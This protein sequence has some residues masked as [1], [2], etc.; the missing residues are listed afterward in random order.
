MEVDCDNQKPQ[1]GQASVQ[2]QPTLITSNEIPTQAAAPQQQIVLTPQIQYVAIPQQDHRITTS[3]TD[4]QHQLQQ[5][6][7]APQ[8]PT[9]LVQE[10]AAASPPQMQTLQIQTPDGQVRLIQ[11][12]AGAQIQI[13]QIP[14]TPPSPQ[15][16]QQQPSPTQI[17][18][19]ETQIPPSTPPI[20]IPVS[21]VYIPQQQQVAPV[22]TVAQQ[23]HLPQGSPQPVNVASMQQQKQRQQQL[24]QQQNNVPQ[25]PIGFS[26]GQGRLPSA[27]AN[28]QE[29]QMMESEHEE[30]RENPYARL[31]NFEVL[32][33]IGQ[34]QFSS[35]YKARCKV[36]NEIVAM[37][38]VKVKTLL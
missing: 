30:V 34:G 15:H 10:Q 5:I 2:L 19:V 8:S 11:V 7:I 38:K 6:H 31:A 12:P 27:A 24:Q 33:K 35:V 9:L 20:Q 28:L 4:I 25:S 17:V 22:A 23:Q 26:N 1:G 36:N 18:A 16:H 29:G 14:S 3:P 21:H 37:K 13:Q 32:K